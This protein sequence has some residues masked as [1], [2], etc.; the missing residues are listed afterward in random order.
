MSLDL[1]INRESSAYLN[2]VVGLK[3]CC[4]RHLSEKVQATYRKMAQAEIA[5]PPQTLEEVARLVE[6]LLDYKTNRLLNRK[7][8]EMMWAGIERAYRGR[9]TQILEELAQPESTP[10]GSL[11]LNPDLEMPDYYRTYEYHIQ[12]GSYYDSPMGGVVYNMG[13]QIYTQPT[14]NKAK[15]QLGVAQAFPPPPTTDP[16]QVRILVMGCGFGTTTW[17]F[18][19]LYPQAEIHA[20]DLSAPGLKVGFKKAQSLGYRV[21]FSQQDASHTNFESNSFDLILAH[22]LFHE[23]PKPVLRQTVVEAY[24]LL[25]PDGTFINSD[26]TPYRELT[27]W[28]QFV[29]DWQVEHNGEPYWRSTLRETYLPAVFEETGFKE[30]QE[31]PLNPDNPAVKFPWLT[32]GRK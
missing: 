13:Q 18:C 26:I 29:T 32:I 20:I 25:K 22:A 10:L 3:S 27:P 8:Q 16:K 1:S 31:R 24:R 4:N 19:Q 12:P 21:H 28:A 2:F 11:E 17:P 6:P 14:H 5:Q 7:A 30:V 15:N 9:E 23:L